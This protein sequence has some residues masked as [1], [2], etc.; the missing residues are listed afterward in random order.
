MATEP[1]IM[2]GLFR[3]QTVRSAPTGNADQPRR[4]QR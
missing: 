1:S 2:T 4:W 3:D